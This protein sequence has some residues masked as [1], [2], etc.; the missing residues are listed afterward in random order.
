MK[1]IGA[2]ALVLFFSTTL[3]LGQSWRGHGRLEGSVKDP[4]GK[5]I[6]G[7]T[8]TLTCVKYGGTFEVK[9]DG[10]GNWVAGGIRGSDWNLDISAPGFVTRQLSNYI[11]EVNRN[12]PVD[13]VLDRNVAA[14]A[15][16]ESASQLAEAQSFLVKGNELF[17][18]KKYAEALAEYQSILT[19]NPDLY[20]VNINIANCYYEM[21]QPE[22]A[23]ESLNLIL[24]KD[25]ASVDA[26]SRLGS[27]YAE[28]GNLEKALEYFGKID[29]KMIKNPTIFY[30]I[31]VLLYNKQRVPEA[32]IYFQKAIGVDANFADGYYQVGLCYINQG[33]MAKA[34]EAFSKFLA[35]A[36]DSPNAPMVQSI[37]KSM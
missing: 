11:S 28:T 20:V 31:G 16:A 5:P 35:I 1:K 14:I 21:K 29:E 3:A 36:P 27:I 34:K 10:K 30:N 2:V 23:I 32:L 4:D 17:N 24:A 13:V 22:K 19:K 25:P 15:S 37:L 9:S 12:K 18:Q 33:D 26:M 7:A 8:I 6:A